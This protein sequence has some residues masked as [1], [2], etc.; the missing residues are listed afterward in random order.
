L[1]QKNIPLKKIEHPN[2]AQHGN[3]KQSLRYCRTYRLIVLQKHVVWEL[4]KL[5]NVT[6]VAVSVL[7]N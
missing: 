3:R 1:E 2:V 7:E 4:I 6:R 5:V